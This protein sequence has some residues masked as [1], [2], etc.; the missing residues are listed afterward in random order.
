MWFIFITADRFSSQTA[1]P[2]PPHGGTGIGLSVANRPI[3]PA[4][5]S[6]ACVPV[7]LAAAPEQCSRIGRACLIFL[8]KT[9]VIRRLQITL[10]MLAP[11]LLALRNNLLRNHFP[12]NCIGP[13]KITSKIGI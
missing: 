13:V 4:G 8:R 7:A 10:D 5:L 12:P 9:F 3:R 2:S 11:Q 1:F 6:P